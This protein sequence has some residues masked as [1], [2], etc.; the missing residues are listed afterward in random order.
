MVPWRA[1]PGYYV[2]IRT[3]LNELKSIPLIQYPDNLIQASV[4]L[5]NNHKLLNCF[6]KVLLNKCNV[7]EY[8]DVV[9]GYNLISLW[10]DHVYSRIGRLP[11]SFDYRFLCNA[12]KITLRSEISFN[13]SKCLGF[14]YRHYHLFTGFYRE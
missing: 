5:L 14:L 4:S 11:S 1:L 7:H 8:T 2:L 12:I 3:F 13:L 6:V 9:E 10:F